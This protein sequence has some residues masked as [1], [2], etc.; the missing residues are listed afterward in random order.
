MQN[1]QTELHVNFKFSKLNTEVC[2]TSLLQLIDFWNRDLESNVLMITK[3]AAIYSV[4][5]NEFNKISS[6]SVL[7]KYI[8]LSST[9]S[10]Q[11]IIIIFQNC[12][13]HHIL[14]QVNFYLMFPQV[15][16]KPIKT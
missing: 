11:K 4:I 5:I 15:K 1:L 8:C 6:N 9:F 3:K 13:W 10:S 14:P 2:F 12:H 16:N 7:A